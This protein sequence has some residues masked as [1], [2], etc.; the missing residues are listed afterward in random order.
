LIG[1]LIDTNHVKAIFEKADVRSKWKSLPPETQVRVSSITLGEIASGHEMTLTTNQKRR[2]EYTAF[3][4]AHFVPNMLPISD[5]TAFYYGQIIGRFWRRYPP[6]KASIKTERHLVEHGVAD[7]N[8][9]WI[10]ASA[11][12]H[13]LILL[14]HDKMTNIRSLVTEVHYDCWL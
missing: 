5:T 1:Y 13:G 2:D 11:W 8:D 3:V 7:I 6:P 12:E 4:S 9:I 10:V 14:T